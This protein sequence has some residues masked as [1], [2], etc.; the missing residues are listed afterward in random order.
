M[1]WTI[2]SRERQGQVQ[3]RSKGTV[4]EGNRRQMEVPERGPHM[5]DKAL[6]RRIPLGDKLAFETLF[7]RYSDRVYR[8]AAFMLSN[9]DE[10]KDVTQ[11]VFLTLH[12]KAHTFRGDA[13][14]SAWFYRL[15][16]NTI[17]GRLR[18]KSRFAACLEHLKRFPMTWA[19]S[20]EKL[21]T[22]HDTQLRVRR[23]ID[24]LRPVDRAVV[25]LC[26]IEGISNR[27]AGDILNLSVL[28]IKARRHRARA[29][30]RILLE[31]DLR[32]PLN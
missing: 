18:Q 28:S 9:V 4:E 31:A 20:A 30:L 3:R 7:C 2:R 10:A 15:T 24:Q 23:A 11:E 16:F 22:Q 25:L 12:L 6:A 27:D 29:R 13:S 8:Q 5:E 19:P 1:A 17:V 21:Y 32:S 14:F 26:D